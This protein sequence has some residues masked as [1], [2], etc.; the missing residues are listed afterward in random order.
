MS[1]PPRHGGEH[2]SLLA[3]LGATARD[4]V[5]NG[6][7]AALLALGV[8]ALLWTWLGW[9]AAVAYFALLVVVVL[10]FWVVRHN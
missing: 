4:V 10:T 2:Q 1:P 7:A 9:I 3:A 5:W 6:D 8:G